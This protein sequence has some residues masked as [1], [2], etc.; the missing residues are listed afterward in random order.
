MTTM[1]D[2]SFL[3]ACSNGPRYHNAFF[4]RIDDPLP[5][6]FIQG[7]PDVFVDCAVSDTTVLAFAGRKGIYTATSLGGMMSSTDLGQGRSSCAIEWMSNYTLAY[8]T[9][10]SRDK[11]PSR[12]TVMLWDVR[13]RIAVI[14]RIVRPKRITGISKP[15]SSGNNMIVTSNY[16]ISWYDLR[17]LRADRPV[18][19]IPH[20]SGGPRTYHSTYNRSMLAAVDNLQ[21]V[22]V[23][24]WRTG[25]HVKTLSMPW[26][27]HDA[28]RNVR[29]YESSSGPFLQACHK[30]EVATWD[31]GV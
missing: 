16:E 12:N 9:C 28:V 23:Y 31:M 13:S 22:Q 19:S 2:Q 30:D 17:M 7:I 6:V 21:Q 4:M 25:Q 10:K 11:R 27:H 18:L 14:P 29:W 15:D 20:V 8:S 26:A 1:S 5:P 24:S 3:L